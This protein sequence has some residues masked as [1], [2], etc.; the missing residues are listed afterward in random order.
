MD[1]TGTDGRAGAPWRCIIGDG[2]AGTSNAGMA[3]IAG[4][5]NMA[6]DQALME[7]VRDGAPPTL[8]LYRWAPGCLSFGRN[9]PARGL[10]DSA[11]AAA[12]GIDIVRRPTGGLSVY[13]DRELTYA[14]AAPA[15]ILGKPRAA[16]KAINRALASGLRRLGVPV[17]LVRE[18]GAGGALGSGPCFHEGAPGEVLAEGKKLVGSAQRCESRTILQHGSL[19]LEGDQAEVLELELRLPPVRG[20]AALPLSATSLGAVLGAVPDLA[21]LVAALVAGFEEELGVVLERGAL[22]D[23]ERARARELESHYRSDE[24]TWRR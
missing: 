7:G 18:G 9:Q 22:T 16:Y 21:A 10:Y 11:A 4:A 17:V 13:H 15:G 5:V 3:G 24:W 8:R 2:T 1:G 6:I 12:R 14:V 20:A 23:G 19:L